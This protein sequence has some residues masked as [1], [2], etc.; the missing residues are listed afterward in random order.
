MKISIRSIT[1]GALSGLLM[2]LL[3][4]GVSGKV[5]ADSQEAANAGIE[6]SQPPHSLDLWEGMG[7]MR[8]QEFLKQLLEQD[9][10]P[11][12]SLVEAFFEEW[13]KH[14]PDA[15]FAAAL[16]LPARFGYDSSNPFFLGQ[17]GVLYRQDPFAALYWAG[18][19]EGIISG[20]VTLGLDGAPF[21][22]AVN[23]ESPAQVAEA[24]NQTQRGGYTQ[25]L[26]RAYA[27]FLADN[28][29]ESARDFL[30]RLNPEMRAAVFPAIAEAWALDDPDG[31]LDFMKTADPGI[32]Q[33]SMIGILSSIEGLS[34]ADRMKWL[35]QEVGITSFSGLGNL[36]NGMF[37]EDRQ[38]AES[39]VLGIEYGPL[40]DE[41]LAGLAASYCLLDPNSAVDWI[42]TLPPDLGIQ[43]AKA[44]MRARLP[45]NFSEFL[46]PLEGSGMEASLRSQYIDELANYITND[47]LGPQVPGGDE[48][49]ERIAEWLAETRGD[50]RD[51]L[52][53]T[54]EARVDD[55]G[56]L[57]SLLESVRE[58][59][60]R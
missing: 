18:R 60:N 46:T 57:K 8:P 41:A 56:L 45:R 12:Q 21:A 31:L 10:T 22:N 11:E 55:P 24:L 6:P 35:Q 32:R 19:I 42:I 33:E 9:P 1:L 39:Y 48:Q 13:I 51:E 54:L 15:A 52:L 20:G 47:H 53:R 3:I 5:S 44:G 43:A 7:R 58:L 26:A 23:P 2:T 27:G 36:M 4:R 34:S 30:G 49:I 16:R 59:E 25:A 40:R 29:L 14:D 28:N 37:L 38:A 50:A 17:V